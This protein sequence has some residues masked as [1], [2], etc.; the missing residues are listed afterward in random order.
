MANN[1]VSGHSNPVKFTPAGGA[2]QTLNIESWD[3]TTDGLIFEV[4][5]SGTTGLAARIAG[6]KDVKGRV[7]ASLDLDLF[8]W[9]AGTSIDFGQKGVIK[10]YV[11]ATK[12]EQIPIII[13]EVHERSAVNE[14]V[15]Y[16]FSFQLDTLS[17]SLVRAS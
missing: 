10:C 15:K 8:P 16:D 14:N 4:T 3:E 13:A 12:F 5:H 9:A 6:R 1:F 17:G 2:E 11:S 7:Q